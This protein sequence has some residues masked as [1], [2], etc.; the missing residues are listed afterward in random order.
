MMRS[1]SVAVILAAAALA[2]PSRATAQATPASSQSRAAADT[3]TVIAV[4]SATVHA[5]CDE[6][7]PVRIALG[8]GESVE[9]QGFEEGWVRVRVPA[10]GEEGCLRRSQLQRVPAMDRADAARRRQISGNAGG[11][12]ASSASAVDRAV[13]S[14]NW[15][16]QSA[17]DS[18]SEQTTFDIYLEQARYTSSY[19]VQSNS[20]F[21]IGGSVPLWNGLGVGV[22]VSRFSDAR[23]ITIEGSLP[24]PFFF[25]RNRAISGTVGGER[26]E[27]GV[28]VDAVYFVP[29]GRR[30]QLLV[31]GGPTFFSARQSV[32][33]DID[34]T[35]QFPYDVATFSNAAVA[36]AKESK[37]GFN[38]GA[39]FGYYFTD[40]VGVGGI[41]R[42]SR[43]KVPFSIGDLDVGGASGGVGV[44]IRVP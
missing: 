34:Y 28:H 38:V 4:A 22:A 10:T 20:S 17:S 15:V 33:T 6:S 41:V 24:H 42:F 19:E 37:V 27:L 23:D 13:V 11:S 39:D 29:L 8:R 7:S 43:A 1:S 44:R 18:F 14:A 3:T 30:M 21:D 25:Q 31:F 35:E 9:I 36:V 16:W 32:V 12:R 26:E 2:A 40:I 5:R